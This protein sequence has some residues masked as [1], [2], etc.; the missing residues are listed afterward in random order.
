MVF[1]VSAMPMTIPRMFALGNVG[2]WSPSSMERNSI[3][4]S[5][6]PSFL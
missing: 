4:K 6:P 3:T 1:G 2:E 5:F